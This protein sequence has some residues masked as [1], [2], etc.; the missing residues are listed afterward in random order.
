MQLP[1]YQID[2]FI[3]PGCRGNPA[4]VVP[5]HDWPPTDILQLIADQNGLTETAFFRKEGLDWGLRWFTPITEV[6]L[7]GHATLATAY[8]L[9]KHLDR[10]EEQ[11]HFRTRSGQLTACRLDGRIAAQLPIVMVAE[12]ADTTADAVWQALGRRGR[13]VLKGEFL[14]A[15]FDDPEEIRTLQPD[16]TAIAALPLPG[17]SVT[18][19]GGGADFVSRFFAPALGIPEDAVTGASHRALA[20]YWA[21]RLGRPELHARQLSRR[22]GELFC[23]VE[24]GEVILAGLAKTYLT[25]LIHV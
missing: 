15:V 14:V 25:G 19:P 13:T 8:V 17:L 12:V 5:V 11:L 10:E 23:T 2:T 9:W 1:L 22:G 21:E 18:A 24:S 7:S 3:G 6:P 4:A 16:F 20:P